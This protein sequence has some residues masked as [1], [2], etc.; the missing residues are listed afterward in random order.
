MRDYSHLTRPQLEARLNAAEDV[1]VL[2]SW[3]PAQRGQRPD[4]C[5]ELWQFWLGLGG[6]SD[7]EANPH[8][9]D[10]LIETLAQRRQATRGAELDRLE[11]LFEEEVASDEHDVRG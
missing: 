9:T 3:S 8:L 7:P 5:Y 1:V 2:W 6:S 10:G 11:Q 4:A